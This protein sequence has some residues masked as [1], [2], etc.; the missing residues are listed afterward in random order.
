LYILWLC[1]GTGCPER[2]WN[3]HPWRSSNAVQT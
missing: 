2:C 3:L 1:T